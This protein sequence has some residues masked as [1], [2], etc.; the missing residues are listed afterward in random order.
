M[1]NAATGRSVV[2]MQPFLRQG[3]ARAD[4]VVRDDDLSSAVARPFL[5]I[6]SAGM[7]VTLGLMAW[8]FS[9]STLV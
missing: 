2:H 6:G 1:K 7:A 9:Q 5:L 8:C 3:T 4:K